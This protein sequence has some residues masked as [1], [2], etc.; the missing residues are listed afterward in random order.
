MVG[1]AITIFY[2]GFFAEYA[3]SGPLSLGRGNYFAGDW[4]FE[5]YGLSWLL[6][7]NWA[8]CLSGAFFDL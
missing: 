3:P 7:T 5:I 1:D 4:F 2:A 8:Y 6:K